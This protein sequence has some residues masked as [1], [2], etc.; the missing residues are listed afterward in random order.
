MLMLHDSGTG[1][2]EPV[3]GKEKDATLASLD[4]GLSSDELVPVDGSAGQDKQQQRLIE[5]G[6]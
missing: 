2:V 5:A 1:V 6:R 3:A 4:S